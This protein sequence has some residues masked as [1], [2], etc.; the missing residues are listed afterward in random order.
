MTATQAQASDLILDAHFCKA[1]RSIVLRIANTEAGVAAGAEYIKRNLHRMAFEVME[2]SPQLP[3]A[4][5]AI[6]DPPCEHGLSQRLCAGPGH[7]PMDR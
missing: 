7:Y 6:L 4:L 1:R 5:W 3:E 2:E